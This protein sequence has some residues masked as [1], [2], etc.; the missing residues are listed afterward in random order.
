MASAGNLQPMPPFDPKT[1]VSAVAQ[2]WEQ[3][4]KRFQ[5][6]LLAMNIKSKARQRAMLLYA[7]GP[8]V[9][10]IFDTL[11]DNGLG[12]DFKTTCEKL[13]EYFS[14]SK[15]VPFEVYKFSQ[16]KQQEHETL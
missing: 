3:W 11:L 5:R 15:N 6:Y 13:T 8:K 4:L 1:D 10:A 16:A 12:D 7:T 14:P 2:R 9:E